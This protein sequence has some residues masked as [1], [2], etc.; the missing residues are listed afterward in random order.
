[1]ADKFNFSSSA[2]SGKKSYRFRAHKPRLDAYR[3]RETSG[4]SDLERDL[5][6]N[7]RYHK[8]RL[9]STSINIV[10]KDKDDKIKP[11]I[12]NHG[13][14]LHQIQLKR[15]K[16]DKVIETQSGMITLELDP[17]VKREYNPDPKNANSSTDGWWLQV[18]IDQSTDDMRK[19]VE[20][21]KAKSFGFILLCCPT[22]KQQNRVLGIIS[23]RDL[24][25]LANHLD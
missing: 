7:V 12:L 23:V 25:S 9:D 13:I 20:V 4:T 11:I 2:K 17:E 15:S 1:A 10:I 19:I 5:N 24:D 14:E 6:H 3:G 16:L 22:G 8:S 21:M 18:H